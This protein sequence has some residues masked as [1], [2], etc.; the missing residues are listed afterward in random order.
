MRIACPVISPALIF[1]TLLSF[2]LVVPLFAASAQPQLSSTAIVVNPVPSFSVEV[3]VNRD[4]SGNATPVYQIGDPISVGV[5]S[6]EAGY[7]YL[8]NIRASGKITQLLPNR[9][10]L[11][12]RDNLLQADVV[13]TFP[14]PGA[15]YQFTVDGPDGLDKVMAVVSKTPLDTATLAQFGSSGV[16]ESALS[17]DR[18][19][20]SLSV[21]VTPLPAESWVTD[22]ASFQVGG[23]ATPAPAPPSTP[24]PTPVAVG[25]LN[26]TSTPN[27]AQVFLDGTYLGTTPLVSATTTGQHLL[28]IAADGYLTYE[29][30]VNVVLGTTPFHVN[31]SR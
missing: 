6:S 26:I 17:Q 8:F 16:A 4:G 20:Q 9:L 5:R 13:K 23:V 30:S 2:V 3:F 14:P 22:T 28:R 25:A 24:T 21:V 31:L 19:A 10:D 7:V 1:P 12:G 15:R 29:G 11:E 27:G 18:F